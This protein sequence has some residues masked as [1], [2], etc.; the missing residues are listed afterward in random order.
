MMGCDITYKCVDTLKFEVTLT[1]YRDCRGIALRNAGQMTVRCGST[2]RSVT[3][4]LNSITNITPSCLTSTASC[5]P[6]NTSSSGEGTEKH[7][8][9][10]IVDFNISPLS[11]LASCSGKIAI[12][13]SINARNNS[14]TTGP[15]GTLYNDVEIDLNKAP[16]N[17]SPQFTTDAIGIACCN[18][19]LFYNLGAIDTIDL[20]SLSYSF[21]SPR[22]GYNQTTPYS[23][24]F[25]Y[26]NPISAYY[27]GSLSFP[28]NNPN[29]TPPIGIYLS[30]VSGDFIVTPVN[31]SEVTVIV[32]EVTEWRNDTNGV[33]QEIGKSSRDMQMVVKTCPDNH[34]PTINGPY[35]YTVCEG[36]Q[37]CFNVG[38]AD[39]VFVPPPPSS[40][41]AADT[42]QLSWN[43]GIPAA[44]FT[45]LDTTA[46]LKTG[47]F[48]WSP[49]HGSASGLPYTFAATVEDDA[50]PVKAKSTRVFRIRVKKRAKDSVVISNFSFGKY[51]VEA[52][53]DSSTFKGSGSYQW[54]LLD[55]SKTLIFNSTISSFESSGNFLSQV[56]IDTLTVK[57]NGIYLL[58]HDI[59]NLPMNCPAVHLDTLMVDSVF[60]TLINFPEDTLICAGS[61]ITLSTTTTFSKG[62][63]RYQWYKN[64]TNLLIGD[65]FSSLY[66]AN[67]S[68]L[69]DASYTI[70]TMD[71]AGN[72][73]LDKIRLKSKDNYDNSF[74]ERYEACL[75]DRIKLQ[76]DTLFFNV[77]WNDGSTDSVR[78]FYQSVSLTV[79][80]EDTFACLYSDTITAVVHPLPTPKLTDSSTCDSFMAINPGAFQSYL[81]S[82][83]E[84]TAEIGIDTSK[85]YVVTVIDSNSCQNSDSAQYRILNAPQVNLGSDTSQCGGSILLSNN[86]ISS[87]LWSTGDTSVTL[88]ITTS[89]L[90]SILTTDSFGCQSLDS[91]MVNIYSTPSQNW[92][93]TLTECTNTGTI[94]TSSPFASYLWNTN[95]TSQSIPVLSSGLYSIYY[96][97]NF[98]CS[99]TDSIYVVLKRL[100]AFNLGNDTAFCGDS[101]L[102]TIPT[103]NSYVWSTGDTLNYTSISTSGDYS[104]TL[105]DANGC[106]SSDTVSITLYTNLSTPTLTRFSDSVKSNL[107]GIHYWFLDDVP[108]SDANTN[109]IYINNRIGSFTA[110][111][112]DTIGCI[113]DTSNSITRTA[114]IRTLRNSALKVYPNPS[115]GK[116]TIDLEGLGTLQSIKIYNNVGAL[117]E[118]KQKLSG[119]QAVIEWTARNGVLWLII[120][121]DKGLFKEQIIALK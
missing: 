9:T 87:Q 81:W 76:L 95:D 109:S 60:Q 34:P 39:R 26:N 55:T 61:S 63:T 11:S 10:G 73:N 4:T 114:G 47:R 20:D 67:I 72:N 71:S 110:V 93:D 98:G 25:S 30:A 78:S 37:I 65:T 28:F 43:N 19:P 54:K 112:Q 90:Y 113:S 35:S 94:I 106:S 23:G 58:Q 80:Y 59:N 18:Q 22:R 66:L 53:I 15:S 105:T 70:R 44:S 64:D 1:W 83:G 104:V 100:P 52:R 74:L 56:M 102:L 24:S 116:V 69:L 103:G 45:L 121:T 8:Y 13:A 48:C 119:T 51:K 96:Q 17:S 118:N 107:T 49:P 111:H 92:P 89:G 91:I 29:T 82:T 42:V 101:A 16:C 85:G 99:N 84:T 21:A 41:P 12:G 88:F 32:L 40:L 77:K 86:I 68:R 57:R 3:L 33:A 115:T 46:R 38:T 31:C 27:P 14:I 6:S 117:V 62:D 79:A 2:A 120:Q 97:D 75:G 36:D 7:V 108:S 5:S 50:C